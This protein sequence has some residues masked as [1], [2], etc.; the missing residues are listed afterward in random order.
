[1]PLTI[2]SAGAAQ[3]VVTALAAQFKAETGIEINGTFGAVGA[4]RDKLFAGDACDLI[5]LTHAQI[6]ELAAQ[7]R[8][9]T[10][11]VADLG[12]VL[13]GVA[14]RMGD[15]LPDV[16]NASALRAAMLAADGIYFPDPIKATAG[17]YIAKVID[18]LGIRSAVESRL[19]THANGATAMRAMVE[20][21]GGRLIG[22]TQ[23]TE[24]NNTAG[25]VLVSI[26][27]KEFELA[28]VYSVGVCSNTA[29]P[30]AAEHFANML[31]S[32]ASRALRAH[33]GYE[34]LTAN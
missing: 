32:E 17:I 7:G 25:V 19:R 31:T 34:F 4:M 3:G 30:A 27:P 15:P 2:L 21:K 12:T 6:A 1:M 10:D 18:S 23:V 14:V 26:L 24:I 22:C 33:A 20:T 9:L 16:S 29:S 11:S 28:T 13:T 5:I 8:V